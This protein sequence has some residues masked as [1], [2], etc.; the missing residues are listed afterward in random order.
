MRQ[1]A[2]E[3]KNSDRG[4]SPREPVVCLGRDIIVD[5]WLS[6]ELAGV[7][8]LVIVECLNLSIADIALKYFIYKVDIQ[9]LRVRIG[10]REIQVANVRPTHEKAIPH[11][12]WEKF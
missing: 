5:H 2:I 9:E 3:G 7:V 4:N 10:A 12:D 1:V 8:T 6:D 11:F